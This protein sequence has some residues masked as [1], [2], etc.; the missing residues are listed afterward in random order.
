MAVFCGPESP[1]SAVANSP[2]GRRIAGGSSSLNNT[3]DAVRVWDIESGDMLAV[4]RGHARGVTC[5]A[6]SPDGR[7]I[8]SGSYD[9]TIRV[10]DAESCAP[11]AELRGHNDKVDSVEFIA[12]GGR[13]VSQSH[14][15]VRI[16]DTETGAPLAVY[17]EDD[18]DIDA[19]D[20]TGQWFVCKTVQDAIEVWGGAT[21]DVLSS[22]EQETIGETTSDFSARAIEHA[23][24]T[25]IEAGSGARV[26]AILTALQLVTHAREA[27]TDR[28][29]D[30]KQIAWFPV[31]LE[32]IA[33]DTSG[34]K[35]AGVVADHL[36]IVSLE[37]TEES[38]T[39][40]NIKTP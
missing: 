34:R 18:V 37:G 40:E 8:A 20:P 19:R 29:N 10:W 31:A 39:Q 21:D 3:D 12:D 36:Y 28:A 38:A 14:E 13:I 24:E 6:Y 5:V 17:R 22:P 35:W 1:V 32:Y 11:V 27:G 15:T 26:I 33:S 16:W 2:D 25:V 9:G 23:H 7:R 4:L 30:G